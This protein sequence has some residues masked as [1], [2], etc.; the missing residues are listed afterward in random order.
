MARKEFGILQ[1]CYEVSTVPQEKG[2][3]L[4]GLEKR[5]FAVLGRSRFGTVATILEGHADESRP[6]RTKVL[7]ASPSFRI[8]S[9]SSFS[10]PT[11]N[12]Q[13]RPLFSDFLPQAFV[14]QGKDGPTQALSMAFSRWASY[15]RARKKRALQRWSAVVHRERTVLRAVLRRLALLRW[16]QQRERHAFRIIANRHKQWLVHSKWESW[17]GAYISRWGGLE[18]GGGQTGLSC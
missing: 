11:S 14:L 8:S 16:Q 6:S 5:R 7:I 15:T 13:N 3:P 2:I 10:S 9:T 12:A 1:D 17:R 4:A 18:E